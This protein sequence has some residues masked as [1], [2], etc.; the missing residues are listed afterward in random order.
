MKTSDFLPCLL[1]PLFALPARA[2]D[3]NHV[4]V[5]PDAISAQ[6]DTVGI[7]ETQRA[8]LEAI[9][10]AADVKNLQLKEDL[11]QKETALQSEL[12]SKNRNN[13]KILA[14]AD[15]LL[16]AE[17]TAKRHQLETLIAIN[18][19]LSEEQRRKLLTWQRS[20]LAKRAEI[21]EKVR[22]IKDAIEN[23]DL[24]KDDRKEVEKRMND[25]LRGVRANRYEE[26]S[27]ELDILLNH[28][29]GDAENAS[30]S[31][32]YSGRALRLARAMKDRD[33][34][35]VREAVVALE[36]ILGENAGVPEAQ[37]P[38]HYLSGEY[39]AFLEP[40]SIKAA[41]RPVIEMAAS[42][43]PWKIG[44]DPTRNDHKLREPASFLQGCLAVHRAGC[45]EGS[46]ALDLAKQAADYLRWTQEQAGAGLFPFPARRGGPGKVFGIAD[47]MLEKVE[48]SGEWDT[49]VRNGWVVSDTGLDEGGLQFDNGICGVA[50][51]E[52]F[53]ITGDER[54]LDSAVLSAEW[55]I[56][57]PCVPNWNYNAFSVELLS[58]AYR[59]TGRKEFLN[60]AIE[61]ANIGVYPGQL[62]EG[63]F[64]GRWLD[65]HNA[66]PAYHFIIV[67]AIS[68]LLS[69]VEGREKEKAIHCIQH[70]LNS[71]A[72][73]YLDGNVPNI[74][75]TLD[76]LL[77]MR[78]NNPETFSTLGS[79]PSEMLDLIA[80]DCWQRKTP[81]RIP[82]SPGTWGRLLEYLMQRN[83]A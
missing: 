54:Y 35:K 76:A 25:V 55:A 62:Q 5:V 80:G 73:D 49:Y 15:D 83:S 81:M 39:P 44:E 65:P 52:L 3:L 23:R 67:R 8:D 11:N 58:C 30:K 72:A 48:A 53:E 16:A 32:I 13:E 24:P 7:T 60:A 70:A 4:F 26:A 47:R 61:K 56:K 28:L 41:F 9:F 45:L 10:D 75:S 19:I 38:D 42:H 78:G 17:N 68:Q 31:E 63:K 22:R 46:E 27:R 79:A 36:E 12:T 50:M 18:E 43:T 74:D 69:V 33:E 66:M 29:T 57:Q 20:A 59:S 40:E 51:F 34:R 14:A 71:R 64:A 37:L 77:V 1:I 2:I 82:T 21:E 6:A